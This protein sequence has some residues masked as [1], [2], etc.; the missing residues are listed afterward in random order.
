MP[1]LSIKCVH[2]VRVLPAAGLAAILLLAHPSVAEDTEK[3]TKTGEVTVSQVQIAFIGSGNVGG[4]KLTFQGQT[5]E[6]E[7]GGLGVGGFGIST[8]EA[9]GSVYNLEKLEDFEGA[10]GQARA[11]MAVVDVS[12]GSLWLRNTTGVYIEL[13]A[14]RKGIALSLGADAVYISLVD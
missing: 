11:G 8:M 2:A 5:Y 6:F 12:A 14:K 7:I 10:Y 3:L 13:D 9:V 1:I 4:G